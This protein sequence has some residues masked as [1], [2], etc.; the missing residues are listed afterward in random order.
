MI[1]RVVCYL[2]VGGWLNTKDAANLRSL[3]KATEIWLRNHQYFEH[4]LKLRS[5]WTV[6]DSSPVFKYYLEWLNISKVVVNSIVISRLNFPYLLQFKNW[7]QVSK[8]FI[9]CDIAKFSLSL[10]SYQLSITALKFIRCHPTAVKLISR[11]FSQLQTSKVESL[12]LIDCQVTPSL[13][14]L[15][16]IYSKYGSITELNTDTV[17]CGKLDKMLTLKLFWSTISLS[18]ASTV[19]SSCPN[20]RML[21]LK[22]KDRHCLLTAEGCLE[23]LAICQKLPSLAH[24]E[25]YIPVGSDF[26]ATP[27]DF[28]YMNHVRNLYLPTIFISITAFVAVLQQYPQLLHFTTMRYTVDATTLHLRIEGAQQQH[29][30]NQPRSYDDSTQYLLHFKPW[31]TIAVELPFACTAQNQDN[32]CVIRSGFSELLLSNMYAKRITELYIHD[33]STHG[34]FAS[35]ASYFSNCLHSCT[36]LSNIYVNLNFSVH[37]MGSIVDLLLCLELPVHV[38]RY[39]LSC[40]RTTT[41]EIVHVSSLNHR[42]IEV[43]SNTKMVPC[44]LNNQGCRYLTSCDMTI[45]SATSNREVLSVISQMSFHILV[46]HITTIRRNVDDLLMLILAHN[47]HSLVEFEFT[48]HHACVSQVLLLKYILPAIPK[49]QKLAIIGRRLVTSQDIIGIFL[50]CEQLKDFLISMPSIGMTEDEMKNLL[51]KYGNRLRKI[52]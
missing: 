31:K 52:G 17:F 12:T 33:G 34:N 26:I 38:V 50:R 2:L 28:E 15:H 1:D 47:R 24:F 40:S 21:I 4:A 35:L 37:H 5:D 46:L 27:K 7:A 48:I 16:H 18:Y 19:A 25:L 49:L 29:A 3:E 20:L 13:V 45:D 22:P 6:V 11:S 23:A 9:F 51:E 8:S 41:T 14:T 36:N 10:Q 42:I 32:R 39:C 30:R 43:T 44:Y